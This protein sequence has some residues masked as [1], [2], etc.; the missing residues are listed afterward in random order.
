VW[1]CTMELKP[2]E[3]LGTSSTLGATYKLS[4]SLT[5]SSPSSTEGSLTTQRT[6]RTCISIHPV[7]RSVNFD[8]PYRRS[9][10]TEGDN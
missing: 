4:N 7:T 1:S 9:R 3:S 5:K 8:G 6:S 10:T 2:D